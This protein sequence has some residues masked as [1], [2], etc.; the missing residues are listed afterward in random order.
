MFHFLL[1]AAE[2][3]LT[4]AILLPLAFFA[5]PL[6]ALIVSVLWLLLLYLIRPVR[7]ISRIRRTR[8]RAVLRRFRAPAS[9]D[10]ITLRP[11]GE[12]TPAEVFRLMEIVRRVP[13][14]RRHVADF[15]STLLDLNRRGILKLQGGSFSGA[16]F[17][18]E[19]IRIGYSRHLDLKT[20]PHHEQIFMKMLYRAGGPASSVQ[21]TAFREFVERSPTSVQRRTD[22][23]RSAVDRS[24][25]QKKLLARVRV[26][27]RT[28]AHP[29]RRRVWML[30]PRG[31]QAASLWYAYF[32]NICTHPYMDSY[33]P[34][35]EGSLGAFAADTE[36]MLVDAAA[37]GCCAKAAGTLLREYLFDPMDLYAETS[38]FYTLTESR[39]AFSE[40]PNGETYFFLPLR[41]FEESIVTAVTYGSRQESSQNVFDDIF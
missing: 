24:L 38:Y 39:T 2:I 14:E 35:E 29:L 36:R 23:F 11:A 22:A 9:S 26:G 32:C 20:L 6:A 21:L 30:T 18:N 7:T 25:R 10:R 34:K 41:D 27:K 16:F 5:P 4:L 17:G 8:G 19:G 31:E 28:L 40:E 13:K 33:R 37:C 12:L 1:W 15:T 3:F